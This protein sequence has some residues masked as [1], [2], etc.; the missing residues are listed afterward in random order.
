MLAPDTDLQ[1]ASPSEDIFSEQVMSLVTIHRFPSHSVHSSNTSPPSPQ[2]TELISI[3]A[4]SQ[5]RNYLGGDGG[6]EL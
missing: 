5:A 3:L 6:G 4:V 1:R 2:S